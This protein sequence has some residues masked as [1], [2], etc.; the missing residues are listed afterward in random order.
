MNKVKWT[1]R[2]I[3]KQELTNDK[4]NESTETYTAYK[5]SAAKN[6]REKDGEKENK[7]L[8]NTILIAK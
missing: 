6:Y 8:R 2:L 1:N 7:N 5:S 4:K 3:N